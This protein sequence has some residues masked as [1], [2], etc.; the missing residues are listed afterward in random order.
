ME[1]RDGYLSGK[2]KKKGYGGIFFTKA[3]QCRVQFDIFFSLTLIGL[4]NV[5]KFNWLLI[6]LKTNGRN[7][8]DVKKFPL[9]LRKT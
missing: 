7:V 6:E 9:F 2:S 8:A 4:D 5:G 1:T 3:K